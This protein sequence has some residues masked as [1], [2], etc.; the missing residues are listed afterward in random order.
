MPKTA[1]AE[2]IAQNANTE[3]D[4]AIRRALMGTTAGALFDEISSA[5]PEDA[6]VQAKKLRQAGSVGLPV[7]T[8][9]LNWAAEQPVL[10]V[11]LAAC[12]L[13]GGFVVGKGA[14]AGVVKVISLIR[15]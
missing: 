4:E 7:V 14:Y 1:V 12:T 9:A 6:K 3:Q 2:N 15:G 13:G 8:R 10:N 11:A 5:T